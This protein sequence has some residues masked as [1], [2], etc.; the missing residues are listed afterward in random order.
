MDA[1]QQAQVWTVGIPAEM[2]HNAG[3]A[4]N[5]AIKSGTNEVHWT[6]EERY[7]NKDWIHRS[8]FQQTQTLTP[9]EYH[10][11]DSTLGFPI[12]IPK[13]YDGRDK[14]F[15]FLGERFDYD[16]ETNTQ[17]GSVVTPAMEGTDSTLS[18]GFH[19]DWAKAQP[20]YDPQSYTCTGGTGPACTGG[21]WSATQFP[22]NVIPL[23]R[24]D[25]VAKAFLAQKP[26]AL[27]NQPES[28]VS[29]GPSNNLIANNNYLADKEGLLARFDQVLGSKDKM[30]FHWIYN[31]Y[32]THPGRQNIIYNWLLIDPTANAF[33]RPEPINTADFVVAETHVFGPSLV[34]EFRAGY[35]RRS[36]TVRPFADKENWASQLG[37][38]GVPGDTF[39]AFVTT[40]GSNVTWSADPGNYFQILQDDFDFA[41]DITKV[42]GH[43][44]FK[45]GYE[46]LRMREN[47]TG[48]ESNSASTVPLPSGLYN[49]S[50]TGTA[51]PFVP[52]TGN[53]FASFLLGAVDTATYT[54]QLEKYEPRWWSHGFYGEDSWR[55][56]SALTINY[57]ARYDLEMAGNTK[58]G[59]KS[60]FSPTVTDTVTGAMGGL[61]NPTG[62]I[63]NNA[64]NFVPR[65]GVAYNIRTKWV[66]R[67]SF[68]MFNV[69]NMQELGMDNYEATFYVAPANGSPSPAM[70][71]SQGPGAINYPIQSNHTAPFVNPKNNYS[72][73]TAT[74]LDPNLHNGRTMSYSA[75][76]QYQFLPN[77]IV[78]VTYIGSAARGLVNPYPVNINDLPQSI[79]TSTDTTLL[80]SV[81]ANQQ[82]N[83]PY[84]Q[85]GAINYYSNWDGSSF[86]SGIIDV[87]KRYSHGLSF[88]V[89]YT[90]E[91][92]IDNGPGSQQLSST[93]ATTY[94]VGTG[95]EL[96][97]TPNPLTIS[98]NK[99]ATK[100]VDSGQFK[101]QFTGTVTWDIPVGEGRRWMNHGGFGNMILGGW[102]FLTIQNLRSGAPVT[103]LQVG[104]PNKELPGEVFMN[105]VAGQPIKTPN[106]GRLNAHQMW[107]ETVQK[108]YYNIAAFAYP[109]AYTRG[110]SGI[111][112][113][114]NGG[115]WWPQYSLSKTVSYRE[116][117]KLTVRM[118]AD[119]LFPETYTLAPNSGANITSPSLFGKTASASYGF[120]GFDSPNGTLVG[121][122]RLEF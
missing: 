97:V 27:P 28:Y 93:G 8:I 91:K 110:N 40:G 118:D 111:G 50:G 79:Y 83:L 119:N 92:L 77:T 10:N 108:P 39:P 80:N 109:A 116:K 70:Y 68:S 106:Y 55:V 101:N 85:F 29:T 60:E 41:D 105:H 45:F 31:M 44:V 113:V 19:F 112:Q 48:T 1:I 121:S 66:I 42:S 2:G 76:F 63:Y 65:V 104:N 34:N 89:H 43:H 67:G 47:D 120:S 14:S 62:S 21:T 53:S 95:A 84:P 96:N 25:A 61:I 69:D 102:T 52:N 9:F 98:Y 115:V 75:G 51:N 35:Q 56:T 22:G 36:D 12:Y 15:L 57:G 87:Q 86:N 100:G 117:Y 18:P 24:I 122:L 37:I 64:K 30:Y 82:A 17:T 72:G 20:I 58:S 38:P 13:I 11:F 16:H 32:H 33:S 46:G 114:T 7:I 26:Y 88:D 54:E 4:E 81:F 103:F 78:E 6:A 90:Y 94:T 49:F 74:Y 23:N 73:R 59:F 3:G 5:I 71:L 107:P 99:A